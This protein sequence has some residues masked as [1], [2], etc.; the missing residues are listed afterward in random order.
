MEF[1]YD[2]AASPAASSQTRTPNTCWYCCDRKR[3]N[4]KCAKLRTVAASN[5]RVHMSW[6]LYYWL[7]APLSYS[8]FLRAHPVRGE[9][10]NQ[11]K[12]TGEVATV[13]TNN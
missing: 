9:S 10:H 2:V 3:P 4:G 7:F 12:A 5:Y 13:V 11:R 8:V 6:S 1:K